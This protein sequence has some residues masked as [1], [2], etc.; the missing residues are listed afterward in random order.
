MSLDRY[1]LLAQLG[2]GPDGIAYRAVAEDGCDGG[3]GSS[4]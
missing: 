4:T 2:A 1:R 3:R